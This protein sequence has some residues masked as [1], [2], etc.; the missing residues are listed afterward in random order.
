MHLLF[1][2]SSAPMYREEAD[3]HVEPFECKPHQPASLTKPKR[4]EKLNN[5]GAVE[6]LLRGRGLG[7][8][9]CPVSRRVGADSAKSLT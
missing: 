1:A 5:L 7:T 6:S 3:L 4:F 9:P 8:Y 2:P